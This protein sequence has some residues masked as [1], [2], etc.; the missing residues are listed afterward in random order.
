VAKT[1]MHKVTPLKAN[2]RLLRPVQNFFLGAQTSE[3][4]EVAIQ[5]RRN[6]DVNYVRWAIDKVVNWQNT[7]IH[8]QLIH[9][10]GNADKMFGV[11][12][13][14]PTHIINNGGH[15]MIM[16]KAAEVSAAINQFL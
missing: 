10:H 3:D 8:P 6:A 1:G 13:A 15:F 14:H 4:K 2:T 5:F 7:F 16:N 11:K 9:I 12:K